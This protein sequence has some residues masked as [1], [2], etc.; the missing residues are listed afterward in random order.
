MAAAISGVN[1][2]TERG[3][4][5]IMSAARAI[6][7]AGMMTETVIE[8]VHAITKLGVHGCAQRGNVRDLSGY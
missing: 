3:H 6:R 2:Q 7:K 8:T 4:S 1:I 5:R